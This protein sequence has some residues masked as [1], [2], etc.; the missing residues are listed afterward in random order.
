MKRL[1]AAVLLCVL[2]LTGCKL[3]PPTAP[4]PEVPD[5]LTVHFIDVGQADCIL[6]QCDGQAMLHA[7]SSASLSMDWKLSCW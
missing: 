7:S 5:G 6:L 3:Q 1:L 2:L 4:V